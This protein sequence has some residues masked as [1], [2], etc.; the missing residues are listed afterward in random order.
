MEN[1]ALIFHNRHCGFPNVMNYQPIN[2]SVICVHTASRTTLQGNKPII[3]SFLEQRPGLTVGWVQDTNL[4]SMLP[5]IAADHLQS[6][7]ERFHKAGWV[8]GTSM[9]SND[10]FR[11]TLTH[12]GRRRLRQLFEVFDGITS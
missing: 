4:E 8:T 5:S 9:V 2:A 7:V 12:R 1:P 3:R 11:I 10:P 6:L